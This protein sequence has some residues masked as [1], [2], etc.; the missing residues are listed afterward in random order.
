MSFS[1]YV[2]EIGEPVSV[3]AL[4][5]VNSITQSDRFLPVGQL[6]GLWSSLSVKGARSRNFR[7]FQH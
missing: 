7:E 2:I 4:L 5:S 6:V 1:R 3:S